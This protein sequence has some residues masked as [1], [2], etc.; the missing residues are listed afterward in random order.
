M[1]IKSSV[2]AGNLSQQDKF[3]KSLPKFLDNCEKNN[4]INNDHR[5]KNSDKTAGSISR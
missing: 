5:E 4:N 3:L 1:E 2:P